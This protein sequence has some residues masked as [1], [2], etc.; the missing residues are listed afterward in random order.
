MSEFTPSDL[1]D[2]GPPI[3][4]ARP[5]LLNSGKVAAKRSVRP[6]IVSKLLNEQFAALTGREAQDFLLPTRLF[7]F[8]LQKTDEVILQESSENGFPLIVL[9][10]GE[11]I[12]NFD[13]R[14]TQ[15]FE[16]KDS[17][18]PIYTYIPGFNI[19]TIPPVV[20]RPLSN[21]LEAGH[22]SGNNDVI[23]K[24]RRLPLTSFEFVVLLL[25]LIATA[26]A[27]KNH[28]SFHWPEGKRAVFVSFHDVDTGGFL[29][30]GDRDPLFLVERK[31]KIRSTWFVTTTFLGGDK[32]K[33]EFLL[34]SGNE[35]GW[36]DYNHDHRLPFS[37]FTEQR[38]Q[39]LKNSWL[40][41]PENYPAGMRTPKL[42]K[43][44]HLY[45]ILDRSCSN[46]R[47][48]TSFLQGIVPYYLWVNGRNTNILE[49][50]I[51]VPTDIV[52]W[53]ALSGSS[54]SRR[55][56]TILETQIERTKKLI[57]VG[58]IISIV[59]HPEKDLSEQPELLDVY[60]QYLSYIENCPEIGIMTG[61]ELF[62]YWSKNRVPA[63]SLV[64][65]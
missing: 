9:R 30:R 36:H 63:V 56:A 43:S 13:I 17:K 2:L 38:V 4:L 25:N 48:D 16:W 59:T 64:P 11:V 39:M 33:I 53:N 51:T 41:E 23:D 55:A 26:N 24:Y 18:R 65:N 12:V 62:K 57:E 21:L 45:D 6:R 61:G 37:P 34:R 58:G 10:K 54:S 28:L 50:P 46:L 15:A 32:K 49:I 27:E 7:E 19:Q 3:R 40:C 35:V 60:D 52:V 29:R 31:H 20:R 42:I 8:N 44:N 5:A 47:Y 14:A 1:S 22:S